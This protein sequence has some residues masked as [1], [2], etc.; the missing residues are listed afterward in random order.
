MKTF[1]VFYLSCEGRPIRKEVEVQDHVT[2]VDVELNIMT[3]FE[4]DDKVRKL[5]TCEEK[6]CR[7]IR[8]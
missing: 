6:T 5:I 2:V 8:N 3:M 1:E 4:G 7:I